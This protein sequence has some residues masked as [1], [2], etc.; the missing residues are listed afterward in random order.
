M[1][2]FHVTIDSI[3]WAENCLWLCPWEVMLMLIVM[4]LSENCLCLCSWELML[5]LMSLSKTCLCSCELMLMLMFC[6]ADVLV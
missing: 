6:Y 4:S 3:P 1:P 2:S 5:M